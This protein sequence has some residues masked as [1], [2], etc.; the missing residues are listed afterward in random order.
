MFKDLDTS[1]LRILVV[2]DTPG[3]IFLIKFYLE[4]LDPD[5]YEIDSVHTLAE[6]HK[7][8]THDLFDVVLLDFHLPDS[9]GMVTLTSSIEKFPE[10]IFI[11]LTGFSDKK[12]GIEAVKHGAQDFLE[13]GSLDGK[14]L[15]SAIK[16]AVQR[17][18][19]R[20]R[21]FRFLAANEVVERINNELNFIIDKRE[22]YFES[23]PNALNYLN[24]DKIPENIDDFVDLFENSND[25]KEKLLASKSDKIDLLNVESRG[26][27]YKMSFSTTKRENIISGVLKKMS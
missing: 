9:D 25:L 7:K 24:L 17:N 4:E 27:T 5:F 16:F 15:D 21:L 20:S 13:K 10:Q 22:N 12:I 6:A 8:L 14:V 18:R 3:D 26:V 11:V 2:E 23:S 1:K 19:L